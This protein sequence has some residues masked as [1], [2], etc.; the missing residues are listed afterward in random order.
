M[1]RQ[2]VVRACSRSLMLKSV[3][4]LFV[5]MLLTCAVTFLIMLFSVSGK[6][7]VHYNQVLENRAQFLTDVYARSNYTPDQ[8]AELYRI[9]TGPVKVYTDF[10]DLPPLVGVIWEEELRE[11]SIY[12]AAERDMPMGVVKLGDSYLLISAIPP[13]EEISVVL[14]MI[15]HAVLLCALIASICTVFT[16]RRAIRPLTKLNTAIEQV[17]RGN[18]DVEVSHK[19]EDEIASIVQNFNWMVGKLRRI[20]ALQHD[21][22]SNVS[23]EFKTPIAAISGSAKLLSA[24]P[25]EKL[26]Q[27]RV[28]KYTGLILGETKRMSSLSSNLLQLCKVE[29]QNVVE[30]RSTFS[31]DE[32]MRQ[33]ILMLEDHWRG[34]DLQL[35]ISLDTVLCSGNEELLGQV[36]VN[37]LSNAIKF[38]DPG[39]SIR[40]E[41]RR[42]ENQLAVTISDTGIGMDETTLNRLFERFYQGDPSRSAEGN[43]LGL[44][45]VKRIL[46]LHDARI[47]FVSTLR[48]GT[49]CTVFLPD[50]GPIG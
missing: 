45:I 29:N 43:G 50:C 48:M 19:G 42:E 9:T 31:L 37:L 46:D 4:I 36:W 25:H 1:K 39:G 40:V 16:L 3:V 23:H 38:T 11:G 7:H 13:K 21:F 6:L 12:F 18:F 30:N 17:G 26:T 5:T 35:D 28:Q 22:V 34:K 44:S 24:T 15:R 33:V 8:L 2:G 41:L 32:Q 27:E 14:Q 20:E 47:Q 10:S 49:I